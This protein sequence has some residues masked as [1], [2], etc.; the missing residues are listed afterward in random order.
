MSKR[1][2]KNEILSVEIGIERPIE[3]TWIDA[4][5]RQLVV[6]GWWGE[7]RVDLS[8]ERYDQAVAEGY[9]V[10]IDDGGNGA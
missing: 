2:S 6:C 4:A 1:R 7:T 5:R 10:V 9:R 8:D 3:D